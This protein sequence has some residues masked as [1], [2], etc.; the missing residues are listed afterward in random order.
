MLMVKINFF[1]NND[2]DVEAEQCQYFI[3]ELDLVSSLE[4]K[5]AKTS[6]N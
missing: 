2:T 3:T 4:V 6:N 1:M 5:N